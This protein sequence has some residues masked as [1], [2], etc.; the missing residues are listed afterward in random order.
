MASWSTS[1]LLYTSDRKELNTYCDKCQEIVNLDILL[2]T[3]VNRPGAY[4]SV[5]SEE[6]RRPHH[7]DFAALVASAEEGCAICSLVRSNC[8]S[9]YGS[10]PN[11]PTGQ[12]FFKFDHTRD[13]VV[14]EPNAAYS[15]T[16]SMGFCAIRLS[17]LE[18]M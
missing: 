10:S 7:K 6:V 1:P 14:F 8:L 12:L 18:G 17:A 11:T 5:A 3:L 15:K 13:V 4:N 9:K 16:W 2:T